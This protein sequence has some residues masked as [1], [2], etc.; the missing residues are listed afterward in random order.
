G[1]TCAPAA[2][3]GRAGRAASTRGGRLLSV[4]AA[5]PPARHRAGAPDDPAEPVRV[6]AR[7]RRD[8]GG[9]LGRSTTDRADEG[10][11]RR[12]SGGLRRAGAGGGGALASHRR[13]RVRCRRQVVRE[14]SEWGLALRGPSGV[15]EYR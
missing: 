8:G 4:V 7:P 2:V 9:E 1:G 3:R 6:G 12:L 15:V 14:G 13:R 5:A 10:A 11:A